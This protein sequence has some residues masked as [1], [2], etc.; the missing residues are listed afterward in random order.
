MNEFLYNIVSMNSQ[1]ETTNSQA[2]FWNISQ[3]INRDFLD[4]FVCVYICVHQ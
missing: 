3:F 2:D 1:I 4:I